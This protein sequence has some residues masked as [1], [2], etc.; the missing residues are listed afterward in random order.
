MDSA[1]ALARDVV[2]LLCE[3]TIITVTPFS[4]LRLSAV[5]R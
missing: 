5:Y 1:S 4:C 2:P 3:G